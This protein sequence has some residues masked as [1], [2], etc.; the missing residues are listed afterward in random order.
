V[1]HEIVCRECGRTAWYSIETTPPIDVTVEFRYQRESDGT[2]AIWALPQAD[3]LV[4]SVWEESVWGGFGAEAP[5]P[6]EWIG[7]G[8]ETRIHDCPER[9]RSGDR[10]PREARPSPPRGSSQ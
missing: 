8:G 10:E 9:G 4:Q 5:T 2:L 6:D 3:G 1:L 7:V